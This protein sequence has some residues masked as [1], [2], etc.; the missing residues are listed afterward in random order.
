VRAAPISDV[1][2]GDVAGALQRLTGGAVGQRPL[3]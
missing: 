1:S 2:V 3:K